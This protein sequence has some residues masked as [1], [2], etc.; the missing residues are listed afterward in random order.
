[1]E[2]KDALAIWCESNSQKTRNI[3]KRIQSYLEGSKPVFY[4]PTY[5]D[6]YP[7]DFP[8]GSM[9]LILSGEEGMQHSYVQQRQLIEKLQSKGIRT[10]EI[11]G[12][13]ADHC[14]SWL[15]E[16]L[17]EAGYV[18]EINMQ[19]STIMAEQFLRT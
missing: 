2:I 11:C 19:Y 16:A 12:P 5:K 14:L 18:A 3:P 6:N 4:A 1:M 9:E 8:I 13:M 10:V 15:K 17:T 7:I